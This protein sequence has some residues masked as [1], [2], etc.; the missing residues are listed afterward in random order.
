MV[1]L[2]LNV[3]FMKRHTITS[4]LLSYES[5]QGKDR[6]SIKVSLSSLSGWCMLNFHSILFYYCTTEALHIN[7]SK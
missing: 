2:R 1:F 6:Y 7:S 4:Y 5:V 3:P